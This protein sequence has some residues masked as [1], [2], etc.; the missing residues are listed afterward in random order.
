MTPRGSAVAG[1]VEDVGKALLLFAER[2][3]A[4]GET[5]A[6]APGLRD[7]TRSH[8]RLGGTQARLLE[9]LTAAGPAGMT[10]TEAA[11]KVGMAPTNAPRAL[12]ALAERGLILASAET[13]TV[14]RAVP[15]D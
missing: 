1:L 11:E 15:H 10:T 5:T 4:E 14:W 7:A 9:A 13:P 3:R 8:A 2:L 6:A 12:K